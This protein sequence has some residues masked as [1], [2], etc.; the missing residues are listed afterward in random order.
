[1][2]LVFCSYPSNPRHR[3]E[4]YQAEVAAAER[5]GIPF[6]LVDHDA[7]AHESDPV[8]AARRVPQQSQP[9]LGVYRGWMLTPE[10]YRLLYEALGAK[11]VWLLNDPAAYRHCHYLPESY[12]FQSS[13]KVPGQ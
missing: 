9:G 1:M 11:G 3:D 5:L 8:K 2:K 10:Q 13:T 6:T 7:L 12:P 4:A